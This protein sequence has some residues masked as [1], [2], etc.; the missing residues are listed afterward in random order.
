MQKFY[1]V[2]TKNVCNN[3]TEKIIIFLQNTYIIS[4]KFK[5][6]ILLSIIIIFIHFNIIKNI[7]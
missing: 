2:K 7:I 5:I 1:L 4:K 6:S 3:F